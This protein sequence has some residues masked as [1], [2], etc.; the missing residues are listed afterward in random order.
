MRKSLEK[1][2]D[3]SLGSVVGNVVWV[4]LAGLSAWLFNERTGLLSSVVEFAGKHVK[5]FAAWTA[6]AALV[7]AVVGLL[8]RHRVA[9]GQLAKK[10]AKIASLEGQP[11]MAK[12]SG[13][14]AVVKTM[15]A[16]AS[17]STSAPGGDPLAALLPAEVELLLRVF[18]SGTVRLD[19]STLPV[20]KSLAD[21]GAIYRRDTHDA[22]VILNCDVMLSS[23]W[24]P[25]VR[26]R[27]DELRGMVDEG[28][29]QEELDERDA[30]IA[31]L[32]S[33]I[34]EMAKEADGLR[35]DASHARDLAEMRKRDFED[36]RSFA[37]DHGLY[38][39]VMPREA[40][41]Y[42]RGRDLSKG[43]R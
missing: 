6:S 9:L 33:R 38:Y 35:A 8:I 28:P 26:E 21:K 40:R 13:A 27:A 29:T 24:V 11:Q 1:A 41:A 32:E 18:D 3:W 30:R 12:M 31:A 37:R 43:A 4:G 2:L 39:G 34:A 42:S 16:A 36:V 25:V 7:G 15:A 19:D 17:A 5:E 22:G 20:A 23:D 10:D 14:V